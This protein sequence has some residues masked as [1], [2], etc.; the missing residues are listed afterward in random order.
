MSRDNSMRTATT[1]G[2]R[3]TTVRS[4]DRCRD[5]SGGV[6]II[7]GWIVGFIVWLGIVAMWRAGFTP[8]A[9]LVIVPPV[10]LFMIGAGNLIGGRRPS[11]G[12]RRASE[13][14]PIS[15]EEVGSPH[16]RNESPTPSGAPGEAERDPSSADGAPA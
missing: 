8:V 13:L 15:L 4:S 16:L 10:M 12:P 9:P 11:R 7:T 2:R 1:I 14:D 3:V 5:D 6:W